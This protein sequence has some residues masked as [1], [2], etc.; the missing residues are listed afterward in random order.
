MANDLKVLLRQLKPAELQKLARKYKF[1]PTEVDRQ[2]KPE[3]VNALA[4]V[5]KQQ[6][7]TELLSKH[8]RVGMAAAMDGSNFEKKVLNFLS[9]QGYKCD[10][11]DRKVPGMEFDVIGKKESY[12][13]GTKWIIAECKNKPKVTMQDFDK[14]LGKYHHLIKTRKMD[15]EYT[16]GYLVTTGVFEPLVQRS[17]RAHK[18][19][20]LKRMKG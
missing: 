18:L 2:G 17:A 5:A 14:F 15:P 8:G 19:I 9:G 20:T 6:D 16:E 3:L 4:L 10:I 13:S 7:I 12:W 1:N 11:N